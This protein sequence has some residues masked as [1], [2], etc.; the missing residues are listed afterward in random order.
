MAKYNMYEDPRMQPYLYEGRGVNHKEKVK[1]R[2]PRSKRIKNINYIP[3]KNSH[4]LITTDP[5]GVPLWLDF[6]YALGV[7]AILV[8]WGVVMI[9][10]FFFLP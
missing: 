6:L 10:L 5:G 7:L 8:F 9:W 3:Q 2:S 1:K 4:K